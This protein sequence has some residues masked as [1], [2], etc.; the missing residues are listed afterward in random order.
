MVYVLGSNS[1]AAAIEVGVGGMVPVTCRALVDLPRPERLGGRTAMAVSWPG[2]STTPK[3][4][5][6]W[7]GASADV[8]VDE[9]PFARV[10]ERMAEHLAEGRPANEFEVLVTNRPLRP[11]DAAALTALSTAAPA[12]IA[13]DYRTGVY[14]LP[15][16][17]L[18]D[19]E[20]RTNNRGILIPRPTM[21]RLLSAARDVGWFVPFSQW[22]AA[23]S[24]NR[25]PDL[26]SAQRG[27]YDSLFSARGRDLL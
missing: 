13:V 16:A 19:L 6:A 23:Y 24:Q 15:R 22:Y 5:A 8:V 10:W 2:G 27:E 9:V 3:L 25:P 7:T 12:D 11:L 17:M 18:Q 1:R 26:Y 4:L 21:A 14:V 20:V